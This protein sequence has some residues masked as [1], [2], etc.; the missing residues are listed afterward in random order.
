MREI[1]ERVTAEH[2]FEHGENIKQFEK[3][4]LREIEAI[5]DEA[6]FKALR[7]SI[8]DKHYWFPKSQ[9]STLVDP[10]GKCHYYAPHWMVEQKGLL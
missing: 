6:S 5:Q 3:D 9:I 2:W 8:G 1:R 10:D 7:F 4:G